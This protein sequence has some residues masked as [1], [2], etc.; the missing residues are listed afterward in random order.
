MLGGPGDVQGSWD[1]DWGVLEMLSRGG[2]ELLRVG[3]G[4][5]VL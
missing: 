5:L 4:V 1:Q 2:L 3:P